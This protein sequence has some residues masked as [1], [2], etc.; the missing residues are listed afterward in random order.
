MKAWRAVI[1]GLV[2]LATATLAA[3]L[4]QRGTRGRPTL[5][6]LLPVALCFSALALAAGAVLQVREARQHWAA[7]QAIM[8]F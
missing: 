3:S 4:V 8:G 1:S 2:L 5:A 6:E 7:R